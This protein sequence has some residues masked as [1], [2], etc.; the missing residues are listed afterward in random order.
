MLHV[1]ITNAW[2]LFF[3]WFSEGS[4]LCSSHGLN[5]FFVLCGVTCL[6]SRFLNT[7]KSMACFSDTFPKCSLKRAVEVHKMHKILPLLFKNT[8]RICF[9]SQLF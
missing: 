9:R 4:E 7:N 2:T 1:G 5:S 8:F 3:S 6:L